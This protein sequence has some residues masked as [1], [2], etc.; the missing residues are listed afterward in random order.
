MKMPYTCSGFATRAGVVGAAFLATCA[1]WG[2]PI[3]LPQKPVAPEIAFLIGSAIL[4]E[5]ACVWLVLRRWGRPRYFVLWLIGMHVLTYPGFLGLL[6]ALDDLRPVSA[7][8]IGE[9]EVVLVEGAII[10][11]L[12]RLLRA[13]KS[14]LSAPSALRCWL[15]SLAGNI[16]SVAAFPILSAVFDRFGPR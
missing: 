7:A 15:A 10:Y 11:L 5:V 6:V 9:S 4:L 14:E 2:N 13:P 12:C 1:A 16:C 3:S 8:L